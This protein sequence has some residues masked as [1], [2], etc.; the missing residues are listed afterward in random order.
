MS[1]SART[2]FNRMIE[3]LGISQRHAASL[4]GR[5]QKTVNHYVNKGVIPRGVSDWIEHIREVRTEPGFATI[6]VAMP[7]D[8]PVGEY[9]RFHD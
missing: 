5:D 9:R 1:E 4:L 2:L 3:A 6:I 7:P 8:T